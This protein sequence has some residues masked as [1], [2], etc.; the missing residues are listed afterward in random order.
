MPATDRLTH[1]LFILE[2]Y[3]QVNHSFFGPWIGRAFQSG[4]EK[5][6]VFFLSSRTSFY[7]GITKVGESRIHVPCLAYEIYDLLTRFILL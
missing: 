3:N 7:L 6:C 2:T 1:A 5:P 4:E